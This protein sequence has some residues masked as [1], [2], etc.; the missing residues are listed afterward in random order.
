MRLKSGF[1]AGL[2][3]LATLASFPTLSDTYLVVDKSENSLTYYTHNVKVK[4]FSVAT[5]RT[6]EDTPNGVFPVVMLVKNPW[7]LKKNIPGGTPENP[8]GVRWIGLEVPGT[9][10]S[11][12]G[13]H[14]TNQPDSIGKHASSGCVRMKNED[15]TWLY[16]HVHVGTVVEIVD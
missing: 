9:D 12:Y 16:E 13:I 6:N 7:Y 5:G 10:G 15:V 4:T 2:L 3:T 14:G 1:L 11:I 8:L